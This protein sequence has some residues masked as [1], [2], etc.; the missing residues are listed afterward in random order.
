MQFH[1]RPSTEAQEEVQPNAKD[2]ELGSNSSD[3]HSKQNPT[4]CIVSSRVTLAGA[5]VAAV[6]VAT[7]FTRL[8]YGIVTVVEVTQVDSVFSPWQPRAFNSVDIVDFVASAGLGVL[9]HIIAG[10]SFGLLQTC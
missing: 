6:Y 10:H 3:P 4:T 2:L 8:S 9:A 1:D 5:I 7:E